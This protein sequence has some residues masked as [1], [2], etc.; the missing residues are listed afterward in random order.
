MYPR[1]LQS[2][3]WGIWSEEAILLRIRNFDFTVLEAV[4]QPSTTMS[5]EEDRK[6]RKSYMSM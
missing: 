6:G 4:Q 1:T 2:A 5:A 3:G